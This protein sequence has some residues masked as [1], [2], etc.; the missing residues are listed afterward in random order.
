MSHAESP[1]KGVQEIRL[2]T[3]RQFSA[4]EKI[5]IVLGGLRDEESIAA[6]ENPAR[7]PLELRGN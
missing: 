3:R 5:Q 2:K 6:L 7:A 4:E 1:E